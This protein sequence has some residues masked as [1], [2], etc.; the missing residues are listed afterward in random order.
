MTRACHLTQRTVDVKVPLSE[1]HL[2]KFPLASKVQ[3]QTVQERAALLPL[4]KLG[5]G[6]GK[7]SPLAP[8]TEPFH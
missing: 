3:Q 1:G 4:Q 8:L 2:H 5:G 7:L 6:G